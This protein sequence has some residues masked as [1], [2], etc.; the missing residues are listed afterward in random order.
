MAVKHM[1]SLDFNVRS[2]RVTKALREPIRDPSDLAKYQW[3]ADFAPVR[4][5][6]MAN[7]KERFKVSISISRA[8][9]CRYGFMKVQC[10]LSCTTIG[11]TSGKEPLDCSNCVVHTP[12]NCC[13]CTVHTLPNLTKKALVLELD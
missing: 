12:P 1:K 8:E 11:R 2:S 5:A 6:R 4:Q 3:F 10:F 9:S 13:N 7:S